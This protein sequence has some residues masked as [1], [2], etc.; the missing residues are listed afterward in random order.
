MIGHPNAIA[1]KTAAD[2][3]A[4]TAR[5][6]SGPIDVA[7]PGLVVEADPDGA[8]HRAILHPRASSRA[9]WH[10]PAGH[11]ERAVHSRVPHMLAV[12]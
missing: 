8:A 1:G 9:D 10:R 7:D 12:A 2:A 3:L 11:P 6:F 5:S 4:E